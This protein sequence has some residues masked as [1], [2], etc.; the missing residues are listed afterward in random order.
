MCSGEGGDQGVEAM[1]FVCDKVQVREYSMQWYF[2]NFS[3]ML[4]YEK[5]RK[6]ESL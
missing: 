2:V 4:A 1:G 3:G 5:P 6:H